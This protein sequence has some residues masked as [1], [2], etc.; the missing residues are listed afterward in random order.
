MRQQPENIIV[1]AADITADLSGQKR[2][3]L[4]QVNNIRDL[5]TK[6]GDKFI[7]LNLT[8]LDGDIEMVVWP[9]ILEQ[10]PALW[11]NGNFVS[12][13]GEVRERF[14]RVSLSVETAAEYQLKSEGQT[15]A[16]AETAKNEP[17]PVVR[18]G[19]N[20]ESQP[21]PVL[22]DPVQHTPPTSKPVAVAPQVNEAPSTNYNNSAPPI[23]E[24]KQTTTEETTLTTES[25]APND[26]DHADNGMNVGP[27]LVR[28]KETGDAAHD[29]YRVEDIMRLFAEFS[30]SDP[31]IL[32]IETG[33]KIVR[34]EMPFTV[35]SGSRLTERLHEL[36]GNGSV[37]TAAV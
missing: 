34:L 31:A 17:A 30:G 37:R 14:G 16:E 21:R 3:A 22:N 33:E 7:S 5:T 12:V 1:F 29:R 15:E 25:A 32:E 9:N 10:N 2:A 26:L 35:Q 28:V 18:A 6:R 13:S 11:E 20:E 24:P 27:V 23:A 36:L 8:L 4:G 19:F